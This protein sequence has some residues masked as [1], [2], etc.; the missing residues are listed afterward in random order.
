MQDTTDLDD[1]RIDDAAEPPTAD[2]PESAT[3]DEADTDRVD[4]D[5]S[6]HAR[7]GALYGYVAATFQYPDETVQADLRDP[8]VRDAVADAAAALADADPAADALPDALAAV[9]HALET[10]PPDE[11]QAA[12]NALFGLPS[13]SGSYPVVPYEANYTTTGDVNETQRRIAT[14]VGLLER[15]GL[16]PHDDFDERQ[17]HVAGLLEL[18]QVAAVQRASA[19]ESGRSEAASTLA[20]AE[21]TILDEHLTAFVPS[22]AHDVADVTGGSNDGSSATEA[23]PNG[24]EDGADE[25][26]GA[27]P[28]DVADAQHGA[29]P[30]D[31]A[32]AQHGAQ[33]G[34]VADAQDAAVDDAGPTPTTLYG[35]A[36]TLA[37][38][39]VRWDASTHRAPSVGTADAPGGESP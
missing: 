35:D 18:M 25:R 19:I 31:V 30:G 15:F 3:T 39:L 23:D 6:F 29:Q 7:R 24:T 1:A 10:T 28:G 36:A 21:A 32:E 22:L 20:D 26:D 16:E 13:E 4:D 5:P 17:D 27:Q 37:A 2:E 33:P 34:G 11:V 14:I 8:E 12:Y 9:D 38:E